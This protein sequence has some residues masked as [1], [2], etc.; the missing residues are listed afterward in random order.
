MTLFFGFVTRIFLYFDKNSAIIHCN[1][2]P[3]KNYLAIIIPQENFDFRSMQRWK[4]F[5]VKE[6]EAE[7]HGD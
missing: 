3:P 4:F 7:V 1:K 5:S 2:L 6:S